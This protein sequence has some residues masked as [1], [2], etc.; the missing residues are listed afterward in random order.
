M[1]PQ[2]VTLKDIAS[3]LGISIISVS[4]ALRGHPDISQKT[5]ELV[6]KTALELGYSPNFMARSLASR[7]SNTIGVV[8][9][10]IDHHFFSSI[11]ELPRLNLVSG[12]LFESSLMNSLTQLFLSSVLYL[13]P[14]IFA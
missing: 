7:K 9:P 13:K 3:K 5:A 12:Y 11:M 10:Q 2:Q 8:L 6:K 14:F 1:R 4:K